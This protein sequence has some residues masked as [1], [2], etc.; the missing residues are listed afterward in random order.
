M[1]QRMMRMGKAGAQVGMPG[2]VGAT[3]RSP[4][5]NAPAHLD[6][7]S[8]AGVT[9]RHADYGFSVLIA[10]VPLCRL[11]TARLPPARMSKPVL[12]TQ[13]VVP[14]RLFLNRGTADA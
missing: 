12:G 10:A 8:C 1:W 2:G 6:G 5:G 7:R 14:F 3:D 11:C 4:A 9:S 13:R